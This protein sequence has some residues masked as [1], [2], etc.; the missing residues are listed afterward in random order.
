MPPGK[1]H[2]N[3]QH[4]HLELIQRL[5]KIKAMNLARHTQQQ[6]GDLVNGAT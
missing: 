4:I 1:A 5:V 3:L 6:F 2:G